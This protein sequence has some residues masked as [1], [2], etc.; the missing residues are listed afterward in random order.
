MSFFDGGDAE[1]L[2][3]VDFFQEEMRTTL[4]RL[5]RFREIIEED[6]VAEDGTDAISLCKIFRETEGLCDASRFVLNAVVKRAIEAF[7]ITQKSLDL[8]DV[9]G[10][11]DDRDIRDARIQED[12]QRIQD[13]W[14]IVD[15]QEAL[16][17][18]LG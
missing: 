9:F 16:I 17:R 5:D 1:A 15:R 18:D 3:I 8:I 10:A 11:R 4:E 12:L 13:Q 6:V 2:G 14:L 7:P